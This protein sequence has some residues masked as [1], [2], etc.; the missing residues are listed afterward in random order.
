MSEK[1]SVTIESEVTRSTSQVS[2]ELAGEAVILSLST[3]EYYGLNPV[4]ARIWDLLHEARRV[5]QIR[6]LLL[7]EYPDVTADECTDQVLVLL[8]E[9][10]SLDLIVVRG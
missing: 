6:D 9:L 7:A 1:A 5:H 4:A 2:C 3:G 8:E 10:A